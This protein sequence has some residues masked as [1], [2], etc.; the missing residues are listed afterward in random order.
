MTPR[1]STLRQSLG[2]DDRALTLLQQ[3]LDVA[4]KTQNLG[5][6]V[7]PPA[8]CPRLGVEGA[9]GDRG[10]EMGVA[11]KEVLLV[12]TCTRALP[13]SAVDAYSTLVS[14]TYPKRASAHH[15][16]FTPP[17]HTRTLYCAGSGLQQP[18]GVAQPARSAFQSQGNVRA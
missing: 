2:D 3:Y 13:T 7:S 10:Q 18:G 17:P 4:T 6:Q 8:T 5:A 14:C 9:D 12:F 16:H 15:V 1:L 11:G